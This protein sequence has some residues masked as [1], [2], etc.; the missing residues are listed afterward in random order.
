MLWSRCAACSVLP[1]H[2]SIWAWRHG[3]NDAFPPS[4]TTVGQVPTL[5]RSWSSAQRET[6]GDEKRGHNVTMA[7]YSECVRVGASFGV[8]R[9][10]GAPATFF[11]KANDMK[12]DAREKTKRREMDDFD[13][14][15]AGAPEELFEAGNDC[16][17]NH[18]CTASSTCTRKTSDSLRRHLRIV[19]GSSS[20]A[21][22]RVRIVRIVRRQQYERPS[23]YCRPI[24]HH[25]LILNARQ[26]GP[27][28]CTV[29][30]G[31]AQSWPYPWSPRCADLLPKILTLFRPYCYIFEVPG[32]RLI[33]PCIT[34]VSRTWCSIAQ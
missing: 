33:Q 4:A 22:R 5:I 1:V 6:S 28:Y 19:S 8:D 7:G 27:R 21:L 32:S 15:P 20:D 17:L 3:T 34:S 24:H 23:K 9:K 18:H 11:S 13:W 10:M 31:A 30:V 26:Y 2:M 29:P 14:T 12:K 16:I 25:I